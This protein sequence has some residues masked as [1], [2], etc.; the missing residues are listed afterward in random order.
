MLHTLLDILL[1]SLQSAVTEADSVEL[2]SPGR[3]ENSLLDTE[4]EL[5]LITLLHLERDGSNPNIGGGEMPTHVNAYVLFSA[6]F[7]QRERYD[8]ALRCISEVMQF[9]QG[10]PS[11]LID[12]QTIRAELAQVDFRELGN[13]WSALGNKLAPSVI[14]R[15]RTLSIEEGGSL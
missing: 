2:G 3:E 12:G 7:E 14:Y 9:F 6:Q 4:D 10:T 8:A 5:V 13:I 11:I 15:F 1:D